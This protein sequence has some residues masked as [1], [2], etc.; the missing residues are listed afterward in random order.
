MPTR[1][2]QIL[3]HS[4]HNHTF[5]A[6]TPLLNSWYVTT[7][8]SLQ[9]TPIKNLSQIS[10]LSLNSL[11]RG[12]LKFLPA[13]KA[14]QSQEDIRHSTC[15]A[16]H[17]PFRHLPQ[18]PCLSATWALDSPFLREDGP[19]LHGLVNALPCLEGI[20]FSH[21]VACL[22]PSLPLGLCPPQRSSLTTLRNIASFFPTS[23]NPQYPALFFSIAIVIAWNTLLKNKIL[24]TL[25]YIYLYIHTYYI[26]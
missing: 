24:F 13:Y 22:T 15:S 7:C 25:C 3:L 17:V 18:S 5:F 11:H 2:L 9:L 19:T 23:S 21:A 1:F 16:A 20:L 26:I 14:L 4:S 10:S 6:W 8:A 12:L